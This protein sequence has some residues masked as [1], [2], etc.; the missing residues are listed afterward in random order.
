MQPS[1]NNSGPPPSSVTAA[2]VQGDDCPAALLDLGQLAAALHDKL[3]KGEEKNAQFKISLS[4]VLAQ[5]KKVC[6]KGGFTAFHKRFCPRLSSRAKELLQIETGKKTLEDVRAE[7]RERV[8]RYR[9]KQKSALQPVTASQAVTHNPEE[10]QPPAEQVTDKPEAATE[11]PA[12]A[13]A[14]GDDDGAQAHRDY[15]KA[16]E[17]GET[18]KIDETGKIGETVEVIADETVEVIAG[19]EHGHGAGP[20]EE[21]PDGAAGEQPAEPAWDD[22]GTIISLTPAARELV[23]EL[24]AARN[25]KIEELK[26]QLKEYHEAVQADDLAEQARLTDAT[27]LAKWLKANVSVEVLK[28]VAE[29]IGT[30]DAPSAAWASVNPGAG[31]K[32]FDEIV[33]TITRA[34]YDLEECEWVPST[35][36]NEVKRQ[37]KTLHEV[38]VRLHK[39]AEPAAKPAKSDGERY[40]RNHRS[41][42]PADKSDSNKLFNFKGLTADEL[43]ERYLEIQRLAAEHPNQVPA[44]VLAAIKKLVP[45]EPLVNW[46]EQRRNGGDAT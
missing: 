19:G 6:D 44:K 2:Q 30:G 39:V 46:L 12:P 23:E 20:E 25:S 26:E 42:Q 17:K 33:K 29:K 8:A 22:E 18:G 21:A 11:Q 5:A 38:E 35:Q 15:H 43:K 45:R 34:R 27:A 32:S 31:T 16:H 1:N 13:P 4:L 40:R 9:A 14:V 24:E 3:V 37:I 41:R 28:E 10:A 36:R 7:T